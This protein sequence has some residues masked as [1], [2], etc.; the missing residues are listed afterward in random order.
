MLDFSQP[1]GPGALLQ[2]VSP[3]IAALIFFIGMRFRLLSLEEK[4]STATIELQAMRSALITLAT[5]TI[6]LDNVEAEIKNLRGM[7]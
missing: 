6:R 5:T 7:K 4:V 3:L 1:I 2:A